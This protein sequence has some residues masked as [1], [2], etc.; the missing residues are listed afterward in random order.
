MFVLDLG[1]FLYALKF[2]LRQRHLRA[3]VRPHHH[4]QLVKIQMF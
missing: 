3:G 2:H 4:L 1:V